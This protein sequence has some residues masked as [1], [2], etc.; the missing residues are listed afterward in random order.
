[1]SIGTPVAGTFT[2][3]TAEGTT[4]VPYPGTVNAGDLLILAGSC[5]NSTTL[6]TNP[7]GWTQQVSTFASNAGADAVPSL[8][9]ATK[10]AA[11]TEGG[12]SLTVTHSNV[13]SSWQI[14][15]FPG[16]STATPLD[17]APALVVGTVGA[18]TVTIPTQT[19]VTAG[20]ALYVVATLSGTTGTVTPPTG[21]TESGDR[22]TG[23]RPLATSYKLGQAAG[24]TGSAVVT[25]SGS[26]NTIGAMLV[27]RPSGV[28][29]G[30]KLF[31]G[32]AWVDAQVLTYNGSAWVP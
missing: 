29:S 21:F 1:M 15:A 27:L 32:S 18:S 20:S 12:T 9:V 25:Y 31:N 10:V 17:I 26:G 6:T 16:V 8:F 3:R 4:A 30:W 22:S 5:N 13:V 14:V 7:S 19:V 23:T 24:A 2:E 28:A 11:G